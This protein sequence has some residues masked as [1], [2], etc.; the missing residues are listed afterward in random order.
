MKAVN[1]IWLVLITLFS[2]ALL[3]IVY[4]HA[5]FQPTPVPLVLIDYARSVSVDYN[6]ILETI[7]QEDNV[8]TLWFCDASVDCIFVNDNML[9]PLSRQVRQEDFPDLIFVDMSL[10]RSDISPARLNQ[11]WGFSSYPAFVAVEVKEGEVT[12]LNV[13]QWN[14]RT[15][16][17]QQELKQWMIYNNIWKGPV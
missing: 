5:Y 17:G 8:Y 9:R 7:K 15:P 16:F 3:V 11:S 14:V 2:S 13:L 6:D 1:R 4:I 10:I 12:I